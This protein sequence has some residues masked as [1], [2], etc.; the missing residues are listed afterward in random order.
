MQLDKFLLNCI[1][2]TNVEVIEF[3]YCCILPVLEKIIYRYISFISNVASSNN[4]SEFNL[5]SL[6]EFSWIR[7]SKVYQNSQLLVT[8][9]LGF[10]TF[11]QGMITAPS[12]SIPFYREWSLPSRF[13]Y[14]FTGNDHCP[15]GF[16][17]FLQGMVTA[18]PV[19]I[20]F[21]RE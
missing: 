11:L 16:H 7:F 20:P 14:L 2:C 15:L 21:Y 19:S 8:A 10:H 4:N 6:L 18:L 1:Y 9:R 12:V 17:T 5:I 3:A 13:P